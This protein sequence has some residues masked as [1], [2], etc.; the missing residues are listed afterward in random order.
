[1]HGLWPDSRRC[2]DESPRDEP[3]PCLPGFWP[4]DRLRWTSSCN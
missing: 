4:P 1:M 3:V 2:T